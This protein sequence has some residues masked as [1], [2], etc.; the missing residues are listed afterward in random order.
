MTS[1]WSWIDNENALLWWEFEMFGAPLQDG[2]ILVAY[3]SFDDPDNFGN[4]L[5]FTCTTQY[6]STQEQSELIEVRNFYGELSFR[7]GSYG[8]YDQINA[9]EFAY[10]GWVPDNR[11]PKKSYA[12]NYMQNES[13]SQKCTAAHLFTKDDPIYAMDIRMR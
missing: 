3:A 6:F 12:S 5:S 13:F 4:Q 2:D 10:G 1:E 9:S 11:E 8:T 7:G